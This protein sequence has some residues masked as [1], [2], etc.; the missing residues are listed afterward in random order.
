MF[1]RRRKRVGLRALLKRR[2]LRGRRSR[3]RRARRRSM[4]QRNGRIITP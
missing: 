3:M 4:Y 1:R 2:L